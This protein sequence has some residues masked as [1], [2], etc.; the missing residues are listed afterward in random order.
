MI[1][2]VHFDNDMCFSKNIRAELA[3]EFARHPK[4]HYYFYK[5]PKF[6][7]FSGIREDLEKWLPW[8]DVL[9]IHPGR[10]SSPEIVNEYPGKFPHLRIALVVPGD[11]R[12]YEAKNGVRLFSYS[13]VEHIVN[14]ALTG[15]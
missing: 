4:A 3:Q 14:F 15:E 2:I 13:H 8:Q 9:L 5:D 6:H 11:F 12:A 10:Q 1:R 7:H